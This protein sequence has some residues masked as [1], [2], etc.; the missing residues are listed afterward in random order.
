MLKYYFVFFV[1]ILFYSVIKG[2]NFI[3]LN[4]VKIMNYE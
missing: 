1:T 3:Y 4:Y 2:V